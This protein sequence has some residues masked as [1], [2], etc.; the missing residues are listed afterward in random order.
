VIY[1]G[2][3]HS[4]LPWCL[5]PLP[6]TLWP[7]KL[8][9][10]V[11]RVKTA[12]CSYSTL[13]PS[14]LQYFI[15]PCTW[16]TNCSLLPPLAELQVKTKSQCMETPLGAGLNSAGVSGEGLRSLDGRLLRGAWTIHPVRW[17]S[18][19]SC[20]RMGFSDEQASPEKKPVPHRAE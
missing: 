15:C 12:H 11:P 14:D 9:V 16:Q 17:G 7:A 6:L 5:P 20:W 3:L 1:A 8:A 19:D 10:E 2:L 13:P 4:P 18:K